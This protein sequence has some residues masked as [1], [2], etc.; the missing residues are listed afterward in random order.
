MKRST[1]QI[2]TAGPAGQPGFAYLN[3]NYQNN[4]LAGRGDLVLNLEGAFSLNGSANFLG[5]PANFY[6][7]CAGF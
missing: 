2:N 6:T 3:L 7:T 5:N 4:A 1:I